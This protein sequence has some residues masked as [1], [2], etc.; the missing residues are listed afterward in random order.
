M[1]PGVC[2]AVGFVVFSVTLNL[3]SLSTIDWEKFSVNV[4]S[5][6][7]PTAKI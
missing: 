3:Y 7:R 1:Y 6:L 5:W 2:I 4:I